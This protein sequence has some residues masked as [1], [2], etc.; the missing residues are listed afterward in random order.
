MAK[1]LAVKEDTATELAGALGISIPDDVLGEVQSQH[2]ASSGA[3]FVR[4]N[5]VTG[6]FVTS[7]GDEF[8]VP[9]QGLALNMLS[10]KAE[11]SVW[12][13]DNQRVCAVDR[14][15]FMNPRPIQ[16]DEVVKSV[17]TLNELTD[18]SVESERDKATV[19][20]TKPD[21]TQVKYELN[22]G[23]RMCLR[24]TEA[25][26]EHVLTVKNTTGNIAVKGLIGQLLAPGSK[27]RSH[28]PMIDI[29]V[30]RMKNSFGSY[31][32]KPVFSIKDWS[33]E[34][35]EFQTPVTEDSV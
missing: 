19:S 25:D 27:W 3:P 29:E 4:L 22:R 9:K 34:G 30:V 24:N 35:I 12:D 5:G 23:Y 26:S 17:E 7:D 18:V 31:T 16:W 8:T 6:E 14:T 13:A 33:A 11:V 32:H 10:M 28:I 21:G 20:G 15:V 2:A 1:S